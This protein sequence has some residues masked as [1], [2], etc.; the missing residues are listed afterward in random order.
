MFDSSPRLGSVQGWERHEAWSDHGLLTAGR[1]LETRGGTR[2]VGLAWLMAA[3]CFLLEQRTR[4]A[5]LPPEEGSAAGPLPTYV[6]NKEGE[7]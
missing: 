5:V 2:E 7:S 1:C 6:G 4:R 3:V